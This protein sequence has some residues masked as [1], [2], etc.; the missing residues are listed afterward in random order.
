MDGG[1][2]QEHFNM[3][4]TEAS[5]PMTHQLLS[6]AGRAAGREQTVSSL[7]RHSGSSWAEGWECRSCGETMLMC[8]LEVT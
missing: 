7:H 3:R 2:I 5:I 6:C 8:V 1:R 4:K